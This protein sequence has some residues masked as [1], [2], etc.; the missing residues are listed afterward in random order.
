MHRLVERDR[1]LFT[2]AQ[3]SR[4]HRHGVGR[5][6]AHIDLRRRLRDPL[7]HDGWSASGGKLSGDRL[8][9]QNLTVEPPQKFDLFQQD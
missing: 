9:Y 7:S 2:K 3:I 6:R 5:H 4:N 1:R 8:R